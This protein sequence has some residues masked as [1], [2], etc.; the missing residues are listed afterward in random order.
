V[1]KMNGSNRKKLYQ[2]M[3]NDEGEFCK[4]CNVTSKERQLVIDHK[5]NNNSNNLRENR[6][7]LCRSCNY[8][9]NPRRPVDECVSENEKSEL[10]VNMNYQSL[11]RILASCFC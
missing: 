10:E 5:D 11:K 8:K 4:I 7:F 2:E 9:K 1:S 6:Q 3:V